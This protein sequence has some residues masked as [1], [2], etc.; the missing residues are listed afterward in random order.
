MALSKSFQK[1]QIVLACQ[2]CEEESKIK[3]KCLLCNFL[4]CDKCKKIHQKVK[5]TEEHKIVDL[6]NIAL[7]QRQLEHIHD[8]NNIKCD[9]HSGKICCLFCTKCEEV[10][11]PL[12]ITNAHN[13]HNMIEISEGFKNSLEVLRDLHDSTVEN[14]TKLTT[15]RVT[16][17]SLKTEVKARY[18]EEKQ[19]I[20]HQEKVLNELV[21]EQSEKLLNKLDARLNKM[22]I[23]MQ[24]DENHTN[25]EY[26]AIELRK[27]NF[28]G[29]YR[30][31][32]CTKGL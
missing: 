23:S 27:Q 11:C 16:L 2:M 14:L 25:E 20:L 26:K 3:W 32:Q 15:K 9:R 29:C 8:F 18:S 28:P 31:K 6:K 4:M 30:L 5:S 22:T 24:A 21:H 7:E 12:C 17:Q 10:V 19:G 1:G 13:T